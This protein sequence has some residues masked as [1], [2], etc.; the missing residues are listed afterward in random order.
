MGV[1]DSMRHLGIFLSDARWPT[2]LL[3]GDPMNCWRS[4]YTYSHALFS[5]INGDGGNATYVIWYC[6]AKSQRR[7]CCCPYRKLKP[8]APEKCCPPCFL[9]PLVEETGG[10]P[11]PC[12]CASC[13]A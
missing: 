1:C 8:D 5:N 4:Q 3:C 7:Q 2:Q 13:S 10:C 11:C 12:C 9:G 6:F